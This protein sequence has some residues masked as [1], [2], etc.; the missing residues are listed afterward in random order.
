MPKL[1]FQAQGSGQPNLSKQLVDN[2][3]ILLAP[4]HEQQKIATIL[5]A[6]DKKIETEEKNLEKLKELKKGL[7]DDLLSGKVRVKV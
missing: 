2:L 7:M 4:L 6:Q 3:N 5:T 1:L